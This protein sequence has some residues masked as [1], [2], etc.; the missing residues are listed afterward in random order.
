MLI[1]VGDSHAIALRDALPLLDDGLRGALNASFGSVGAGM[2]E[3]AG[4]LKYP[5]HEMRDGGIVFPDEG[6]QRRFNAIAGQ[7]LTLDSRFDGIVGVLAGQHFKVHLKRP[8]WN[9]FSI[10]PREKKHFVTRAAF[11]ELLDNHDGGV[12]RFLS[13]LVKLRIRCFLLG[14]PPLRKKFIDQRLTI[15]PDEV[16][17]LHQALCQWWQEFAETLAIPFVSAPAHVIENNMLKEMYESSGDDVHHANPAYG[18]EMWKE[19]LQKAPI[20]KQPR[21]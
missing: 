8:L 17:I 9:R 15:P 5:F 10:V 12:R 13:D 7:P 11:G 20:I 18:V 16:L 14:P 19:I 2:I 4:R 21:P 1:A 6:I 3:T